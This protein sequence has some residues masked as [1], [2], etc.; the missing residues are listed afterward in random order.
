MINEWTKEHSNYKGS[1][2]KD[3]DKYL[4]I[5]LE[6]TGGVGDYEEKGN[7]IIRKIAKEVAITNDKYI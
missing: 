7:K 3:N 5:V 4:Q 1:D 2:E 6:S